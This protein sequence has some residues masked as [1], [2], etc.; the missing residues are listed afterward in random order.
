MHY[1]Y[2]HKHTTCIHTHTNAYTHTHT[3]THKDTGCH[4]LLHAAGRE[5]GVLG[6]LQVQVEPVGQLDV[7]AQL[8]GI[9][10]VL[11][12]NVD[13]E[14]AEREGSGVGQLGRVVRGSLLVSRAR[15]FLWREKS[16]GPRDY[17]TLVIYDKS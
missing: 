2:T 14:T 12:G 11:I 16:S 15:R 4:E 17:L 9:V 5:G 13:Q 6:S 1:M 10:F 8:D 7:G 3:H